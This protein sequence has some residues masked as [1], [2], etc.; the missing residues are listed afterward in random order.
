MYR[1]IAFLLLLPFAMIAT[2]QQERVVTLD[3][4]MHRKVPYFRSLDAKKLSMRLTKGL[5]SDSEKV[6]VL[7]HWITHH[8]KYDVKK[9]ENFDAER[10]PVKRILR[11]RKAICTGYADLF[12]AL[13][14]SCGVMSANVSGYSRNVYTDLNDK[15]YLGDHAWN[16]VNISGRW[17]LLD[18]TWDAGYIEFIKR[19]TF[20]HV[21][22]FISF[23]LLD[24]KRDKLHF[25][26]APNTIWFLRD[27]TFFKTDHIA[28]DPLWLLLPKPYVI[29]LFEQ[30]S[31]Y[32]LGKRISGDDVSQ[33]SE[34]SMRLSA[35][36]TEKREEIIKK[37]FRVYDFN[38]KNKFY[39]GNSYALM[40][41][42][43]YSRIVLK[44]ADTLL[45][46]QQ[47]DSAMAKLDSAGYFYLK[48]IE[49]LKAQKSELDSNNRFKLHN[50]Q[51]E[52]RYLVNTTH[53]SLQFLKSG[54]NIASTDSKQIRTTIRR[55][56][57]QLRTML[58]SERYEKAKVP[59]STSVADSTNA[60]LNLMLYHD[61]LQMLNDSIR[62]RFNETGVLLDSIL[63]RLKRHEIRSQINHANA[64]SFFIMRLYMEDDLDYG[65]SIAKDAFMIQ[66]R[67]DDTLIRN[68][69]KRFIM[70]SFN[71]ELRI[72]RRQ[73]STAYRYHRKIASESVRLKRSCAG[74]NESSRYYNENLAAFEK[75]ITEL[76]G[77][78]KN[79]RK[80][81]RPLVRACKEQ[82]FDVRHEEEMYRHE[83]RRE[84]TNARIRSN[85]INKHNRQ[86]TRATMRNN[87]ESIR[88]YKRCQSI[89]NKLALQ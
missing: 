34:E 59:D 49:D 6:V 50:V 60:E 19:S 10:I 42:D 16:A 3:E 33:P 67:M 32:Y 66:K 63:N 73:M 79:F 5:Q 85:Y 12:T 41:E 28:E 68:S 81:M 25:V 69:E 43:I 45:V 39:I 20:G 86:Q 61:S 26:R 77:Q 37:G 72:M 35:M 65:L 75:N 88:L 78:L 51:R 44:P 9:F 4:A 48:C 1:I 56:Q 7:H 70:K 8:I 46:L 17:Y 80:E 22:H 89:K 23:G 71:A 18:A 57:S 54:K 36:Q 29:E 55:N 83:L 76:N 62:I 31:S 74:P 52:N 15:F 14:Q 24:H 11:S 58:R 2:A 64:F 40:A 47:C 21:V 13:A 38:P 30:D 82:L 27:G 53:Q 87:S 84:Y